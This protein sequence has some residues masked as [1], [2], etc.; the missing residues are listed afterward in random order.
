[1]SLALIEALLDEVEARAA[2]STVLR[3]VEAFQAAVK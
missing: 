2:T 1:M 3:S